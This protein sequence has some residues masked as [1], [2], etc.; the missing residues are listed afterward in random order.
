MTEGRGEN[1]ADRG[2]VD[3]L[4]LSIGQAAKLLG[5]PE[6]AVRQHVA[7]GAPTAPNRTLNLVHY[8]AWL[9]LQLRRRTD[10]A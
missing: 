5:L 3:P 4:A 1:P 6:Q 9:N 10:G 7:E 8:A 2:P